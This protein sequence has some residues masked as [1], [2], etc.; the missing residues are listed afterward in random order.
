M[1]SKRPRKT[2]V[3]IQELVQSLQET[4][5]SSRCVCVISA[6]CRTREMLWG[7]CCC[8]SLPG[9]G[10]RGGQCLCVL[11]GVKGG[12]VVV[13]WG[14]SLW[15]ISDSSWWISDSCSPRSSFKNKRNIF[16]FLTVLLLHLLAALAFQGKTLRGHFC[17]PA[18]HVWN[19]NFVSF[20]NHLYTKSFHEWLPL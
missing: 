7:K 9:L 1:L 3:L 17:L 12:R 15:C 5:D 4:F 19:C 14:E 18:S 10:R 6:L 2:A 13:R 20:P 16:F 11:L 8:C